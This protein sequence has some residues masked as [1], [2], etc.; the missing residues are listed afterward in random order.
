MHD[1]NPIENV[2]YKTLEGDSWRRNKSTEQF[3]LPFCTFSLIL[4]RGRATA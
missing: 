1:Q 2:I 4:A 3:G